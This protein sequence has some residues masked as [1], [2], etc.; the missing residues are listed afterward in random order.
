MITNNP[1]IRF[2]ENNFINA[3]TLNSF[4]SEVSGFPASNSFNSERSK[5]W[6]PS[7]FR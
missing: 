6:K 5:I 3:L 4:S 7:G 2:C 1:R